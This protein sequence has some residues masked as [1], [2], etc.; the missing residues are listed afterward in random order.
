MYI[1]A[2]SLTEERIQSEIAVIGAGPAGISIALEF[3]RQGHEVTLIE[4]GSNR[5]S[6]RTQTLGDAA[7]G[8]ARQ[9]PMSESTRRQI[10]GASTIWGGRCVPYDPIDF[11]NRSYIPH[12]RWPVAF[13]DIA[14]YFEKTTDYF[15]SGRAVFNLHQTGGQARKSIVPGLPDGDILSSDLER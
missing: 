1:D 14:P 2:E 5:V 9:A 10:G 4:S 12:A 6:A 7:L 3:A 15:R 11:A 13:E 8:S